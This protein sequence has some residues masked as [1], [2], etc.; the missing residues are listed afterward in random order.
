MCTARAQNTFA[1]DKHFVC[2]RRRSDCD[3]CGTKIELR[4]ESGM[5]KTRQKKTNGKAEGTAP[6]VGGKAYAVRDHAFDVVV[7]GT[8]G[9][10]VSGAGGR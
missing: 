6:A 8:G 1:A 3:I 10:I 5:A 4:G 9:K 7:V 2:I